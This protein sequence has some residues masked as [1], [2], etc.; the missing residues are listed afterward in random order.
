MR[1]EAWR[2]EKAY[3]FITA[4]SGVLN[5]NGGETREGE[6]SVLPLASGL[7]DSLSVCWA[8]IPTP[9]SHDIHSRLGSTIG[10]CPRP[11]L[12][13]SPSVSSFPEELAGKPAEGRLGDELS[14]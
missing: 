7:R 10:P 6:S 1:K 3:C 14:W 13:A 9:A 2:L 5:T 8:Q 11:G 12:S 4:R